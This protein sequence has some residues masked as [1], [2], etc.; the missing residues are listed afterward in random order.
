MASSCSGGRDK[1]NGEGKE[2]NEADD[3][4]EEE[5]VT[6][7]GNKMRLGPGAAVVVSVA[8]FG[9]DLSGYCRPVSMV[10]SRTWSGRKAN[11]D[12]RRR[13][14]PGRVWNGH[15]KSPDR[16]LKDKAGDDC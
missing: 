4:A 2:K 14:A 3:E 5:S 1:L 8:A 9:G 11:S 13:E 16:W 12:G 10:W 7:D 15:Q 6:E